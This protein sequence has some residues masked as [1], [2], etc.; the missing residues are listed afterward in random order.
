M[1]PIIENPLWT[2]L[3][4]CLVKLPACYTGRRPLDP[5]MHIPGLSAT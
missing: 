2:I 4:A 5:E 1:T 3:R